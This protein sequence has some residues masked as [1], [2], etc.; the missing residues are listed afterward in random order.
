MSQST[1]GPASVQGLFWP[2]RADL[3]DRDA[4]ECPQSAR[5]DARAVVL[6][7]RRLRPRPTNI[8]FFDPAEPSR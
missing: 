7:F 1:T 8:W 2:D 6:P 4:V 5:P 3:T